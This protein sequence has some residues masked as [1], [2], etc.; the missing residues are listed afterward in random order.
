M[1]LTPKT[2]N[3]TA[4]FYELVL[5]ENKKKKTNE[6]STSMAPP[7]EPTLIGENLFDDHFWANLN[8]EEEEARDNPTP[9]N[10]GT[11]PSP[12]PPRRI[13]TWRNWTPLVKRWII[14]LDKVRQKQEMLI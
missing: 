14:W 4:I 5:R 10:E 8:I 13:E 7:D 6:A 12:Q 9:Q 11:Q 2:V 1:I 3:H